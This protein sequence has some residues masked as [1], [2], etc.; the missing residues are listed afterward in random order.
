M[1]RIADHGDRDSFF[2]RVEGASHAEAERLHLLDAGDDV[3]ESI[4]SLLGGIE[5]DPAALCGLARSCDIL[6]QTS[7]SFEATDDEER[8]IRLGPATLQR[9]AKLGAGIKVDLY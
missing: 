2:D 3:E 6:I 8:S 5:A 9:L 4:N 7:C 1:N